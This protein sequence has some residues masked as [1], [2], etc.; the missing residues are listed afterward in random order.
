M[1]NKIPLVVGTTGWHD[2]VDTVQQWINDNN[3]S[4]I[5]ASNFS[6]GVHLFR[7][8][9]ELLAKT[10]GRRKDYGVK[11]LEAHHTEKLDAPSGTAISIA[12]DII[13]AVPGLTKWENTKDPEPHT[14]GIVAERIPDETGTHSVT[15]ASDIDEITL[16]HKAHSRKGF[17]LGAV[18]ASEWIVN[19]KGLYG[20]GDML[21]N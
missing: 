20:I 13:K 8:A 17:A 19:H 11:L 7:Q 6:I 21:K 18:V 1:E 3:G 15:Y 9:N 5:Y 2:E 14:L 4:L 12:E 16:T 10:L